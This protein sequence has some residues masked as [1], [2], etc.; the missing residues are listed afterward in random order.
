MNLNLINKDPQDWNQ[1]DWQDAYNLYCL[2]NIYGPK[3]KKEYYH[4]V[5]SNFERIN[6]VGKPLSESVCKQWLEGWRN[7][8]AWAKEH[9]CNI[10]G[11][12]LENSRPEINLESLQ[13][14][15]REIQWQLM[16]K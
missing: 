2:Q 12:S 9:K 15:V 11:E 5:L 8:V 14:D 10:N 1:E 6:S 7:A 13:N 3:T 16:Q 4:M